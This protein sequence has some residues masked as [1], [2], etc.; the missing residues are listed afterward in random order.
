MTV[1]CGIGFQALLETRGGR[2][3]GLAAIFAGLVP[4]MA[5][6]VLIP[7]SDRLIPAATWLIGISPAS[8]PFYASATLLPFAE[9]PEQAAG[10]VPRAFFFWL[11]V[12][13]LMA[14]WLSVRLWASRKAM[15]ARVFEGR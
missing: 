13:V 11:S 9:L 6:A 8:M 2:V 14:G 10:A 1:A 15:A 12:A 7:I 4:I 5:G 3:V